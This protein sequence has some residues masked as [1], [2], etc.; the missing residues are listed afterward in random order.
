MTSIISLTK[1]LEAHLTLL[2][3]KHPKI[4]ALIAFSPDG[5]VISSHS[6]PGQDK[7]QISAFSAMLLKDALKVTNSFHFGEFKRILLISEKGYLAVLNVTE[8]I[9]VAMLSSE[10]SI[11]I[12]AFKDLSKITGTL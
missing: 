6:Q 4:L 10:Q 9:K 5:L 8:E 2:M 11:F 3:A 12:E 7:E 1:R